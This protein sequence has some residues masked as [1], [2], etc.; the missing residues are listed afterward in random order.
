M[1]NIDIQEYFKVQK[2]NIDKGD[3]LKLDLRRLTY[4]IQI[5][6][7][8][9]E[10]IASFNLQK[11]MDKYYNIYASTNQLDKIDKSISLILKIARKYVEEP[12][13]GVPYSTTKLIGYTK[14]QY[15]IAKVKWYK[16]QNVSL[17]SMKKRKIR[18][19]QKIK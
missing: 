2:F 16:D 1:I 6:K 9:E 8:M 4:R 15:W 3:S 19:E 18:Q 10:L 11:I 14:L 12:M 17:Q 13:R 7:K 5:I